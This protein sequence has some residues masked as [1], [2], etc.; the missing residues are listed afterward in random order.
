MTEPVASL[1]LAD[2]SQQFIFV[3]NQTNEAN[4]AKAHWMIKNSA[5]LR[6]TS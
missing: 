1:Y 4:S 2:F 6:Y 5:D 3:S